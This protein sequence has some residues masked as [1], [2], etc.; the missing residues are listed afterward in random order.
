MKPGQVVLVTSLPE[1]RGNLGDF[2]LTE[3]EAG[4]DRLS[5]KVVLIWAARNTG[6]PDL[7]AGSPPPPGL[8]PVEPPEK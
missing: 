7:P 8:V 4:S 6:A 1:R 3:S 5:Q 2:L